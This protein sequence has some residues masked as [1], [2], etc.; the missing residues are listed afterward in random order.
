MSKK[1]LSVALALIFVLSTFAVS[2]F[3]A[4]DVAFE[5]DDAGYTQTWTLEKGNEADGVYSVNVYLDANYKVGAIQFQIANDDGNA[6]LAGVDSDVFAEGYDIQWTAEGLVFIVPTPADEGAEAVELDPATPIAVLTYELAEGAT[7]AT[8]AIADDAK[9]A[10]NPGGSLIA[11]RM[12]NDNLA[13]GTMICGQEVV[14]VGESVTL[15]AAAAPADLALTAA[16]TADGVVI[17]TNKTLNGAY[18]GVVYGFALPDN[19]VAASLTEAYYKEKLTATNGGSITVT[20]TPYIARP[21]SYGT[22]T[23]ITVLNADGT[24]TGK[25]YVVVIFGDVTG[26]SKINNSD[27]SGILTISKTSDTYADSVKR[28]AA[29]IA[30]AA[31]GMS[32]LTHYKV[33]STD[34]SAGLV[35]VKNGD[36]KFVNGTKKVTQADLAASHNTYNEYYQ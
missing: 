12:D 34:L 20:K 5:A 4:G 19:G 1:I 18:A 7:S 33:D 35:A 6:V 3:A 13:N 11:V 32:A 8:I 29:N 21:A 28:L 23:T 25:T 17:D 36:G 24:S 16:G 30:V 22:G 10:D 14:S 31:R 9:T 15:G 27:I 26:D 2:A